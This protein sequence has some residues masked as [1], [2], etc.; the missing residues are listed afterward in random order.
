M[1]REVRLRS[2]LLLEKI[3]VLRKLMNLMQRATILVLIP[4][5]RTLDLTE[6]RLT[7]VAL[8]KTGLDQWSNRDTRPD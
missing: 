7:K 3:L 4:S 1:Y 8:H 2:R 5:W 6:G